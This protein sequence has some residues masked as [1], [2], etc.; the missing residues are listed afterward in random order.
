MKLSSSPYNFC[1]M[2]ELCRYYSCDDSLLGVMH[3]INKKDSTLPYLNT[4]ISWGGVDARPEH[5]Q[6]TKQISFQDLDSP[7]SQ[8]TCQSYT[9]V[10]SSGDDNP[11]IQISFSTK[12]GQF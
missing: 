8:S 5:M 7:S 3:Q 10:A 6:T 11:S 12:S 2:V 4:S 1:V 9:E